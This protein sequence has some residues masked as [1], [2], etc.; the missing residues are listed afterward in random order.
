M[1]NCCADCIDD[2]FLRREFFQKS[3]LIG[4]CSYCNQ[5]NR[6]LVEA[7]EFASRFEILIENYRVDPNGKLLI[8]FLRSDWNLFPENQLSQLQANVLLADILD[9]GETV[10]K[11]YSRP[12]FGTSDAE[13]RWDA[14]RS[15]LKHIN[16][17]FPKTD[18]HLE[19]LRNRLTGIAIKSSETYEIWYRARIQDKNECF[20]IDEMGAPP[21]TL[22][23][24]GRANPAGIPYLYLASE[25]QTAASEVRPHTGEKLSI[26]QFAL[27]SSLEFVDLRH[28][29]RSFSPLIEE[30]GDEEQFLKLLIEIKFLEGL[31]DE[32]TRPVVPKSATLEYIPTQYLCEFI[33]QCGYDGVLYRSSV[34][35][36]VNLALFDPI[37][38]ECQCVN[39]LAV[40]KVTVET[41]AN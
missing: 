32:L 28:P 37:D 38:A 24:N 39:S 14:L 34:G 1:A 19:P 22:A 5:P 35:N 18:I 25:P 20:S 21:N 15:E 8:E 29:R 16:R 26:A 9:N 6:H 4:I 7:N 31:A 17:F 27:K 30:I 10:R 2:S 23:S 13:L 41:M 40:A 33:K 3:K 11:K 36:G 12:T